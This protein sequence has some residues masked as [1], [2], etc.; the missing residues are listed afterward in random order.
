MVESVEVVIKQPGHPDRIVRLQEGATRMGR[1]EDNEVVLSDVGVS[2]RHAQVYVSRGE[3]TVEDLGSGNGT[4][5]NGY[6]IAS[7]PIQ[8]GDEIVVDPFVLHFRISGQEQV[9]RP[10]AG[11]P[12]DTT[13]ARLEVVVGTGMAGSS[14]PITSRGLSIGRSEDRDVVIP[15]PAS[16]RHHCQITVQSVDYVLRDM[17]SANGVFVNAVRVRE[18]TLADG[19]LVRIGNT[20]MR[21][22]RYDGK[23]ADNTTHLVSSQDYERQSWAE[24]GLGPSGGGAPLHRDPPPVRRSRGRPWLAVAVGMLLIAVGLL[25]V[26]VL[27]LAIVVLALQMQPAGPVTFDAQPPRWQLKLP[28]G[29]EGAPVDVLFES[30]SNKIFSNDNSGALQDF[31]RVMQADP[32]YPSV[33]KFAYA[34]GESLVVGVL[35]DEFERVSKEFG[36]RRAERDKLMKQLGRGSARTRRKTEDQLAD[37][38]PD[39][40]EVIEALKL[41]AT[42]EMVALEKQAAAAFDLLSRDDF[43]GAALGYQEVLATATQPSVRTQALTNL[44][45]ASKEV[46]RSS[47]MSWTEAVLADAAGD[48]TLA[49]DQYRALLDEHPANPSAKVRLGRVTTRDGSANGG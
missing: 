30:G 42:D 36:T 3:V 5:Y 13:P 29:L 48:R 26:L 8:D 16:S 41:K 31:F 23:G 14:Y 9:M 1:A 39:D 43:D 32:G 4:Y 24:P 28:P 2:R 49:R 38:F 7:Q 11:A 45:T 20:E 35:E 22:V 33:D 34:A 47:Q 6:R 44:R 18:C 21:F 10:D 46:A 25:V 27:V 40:P 37:K 17:G 15:D 12:A 19:D